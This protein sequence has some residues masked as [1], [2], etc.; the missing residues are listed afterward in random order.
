MKYIKIQKIHEPAIIPEE[1]A[2]LKMSLSNIEI[3]FTLTSYSENWELKGM[4][5]V[6]I[7][8]FY[9]EFY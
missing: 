5:S 3:V 6:F 7:Q 8:C 9:E 2:K 4:M 1:K